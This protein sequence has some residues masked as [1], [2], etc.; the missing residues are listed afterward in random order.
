MEKSIK[1]LERIRV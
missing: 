1:E